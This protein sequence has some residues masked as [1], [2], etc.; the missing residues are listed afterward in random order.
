[1]LSST[2]ALITGERYFPEFEWS[3]NLWTH[4]VF[5]TFEYWFGRKHGVPPCE[6][7]GFVDKTGRVHIAVHTWES[8]FAHTEVYIRQFIK[9]FKFVPV[10]IYIPQLAPAGMP[11]RAQSPYLFAIAFVSSA[12]TAFG[13][14]PQTVSL[15]VSGSDTALAMYP[16]TLN[17]TSTAPTYNSVAATSAGVASTYLGGGRH[18]VRGYYL[19]NPTTGTNTASFG[20]STGNV[21][22]FLACYSGVNQTIAP[23]STASV[24]TGSVA[25]I[26]LSIT[27]IRQ[28][29]VV[30]LCEVDSGAG[31]G[32]DDTAGAGVTAIR[33]KDLT[34]AG[35]IADGT[36]SPGSNSYTIN[37]LGSVNP[38]NSCMIA[39]AFAP[40]PPVSSIELESVTTGSAA[41][42]TSLTFARISSAYPNRVIAIGIST[43]GTIQ[44]VT[45]DGVTC[46][47][48]AGPS[49]G[50]Q[51]VVWYALAAP[52]AGTKNVIITLTGTSFIY[53]TAV[54]LTGAKQTGIPDAQTTNSAGSGTS[55]TTTITTIADKSWGLT[56]YRNDNDGNSTAGT[57]SRQI[58]AFAGFIQIY[59]SN[60]AKTP[61]GSLSMTSN[62]ALGPTSIAQ[63]MISLA[64]APAPSPLGGM[65]LMMGVG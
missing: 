17:D 30:S 37:L 46:S 3:P 43:G 38:T 20:S 35:C 6:F 2:L 40:V 41:S 22:A 33:T 57:G 34:L 32:P 50:G 18:G 54:I 7:S 42:A 44:S 64:P 65:L 47:A 19:L 56:V 16:T 23:D 13:A 60:G 39:M 49:G 29:C 11:F 4:N 63:A 27:T 59:D 51:P 15:T 26:T 12:N 28:N 14:A 5:R 53:A 52:N 25:A 61:A 36:A 45:D 24:N 55:I 31:V 58:S 21:E 10:R 9:S 62:N 1:M 48:V 8:A